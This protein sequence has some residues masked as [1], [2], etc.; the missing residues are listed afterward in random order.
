MYIS[1][2]KRAALLLLLLRGRPTPRLHRYVAD[3]LVDAHACRPAG[4][5]RR[6]TIPAADPAAGPRVDVDLVRER[7]G[8]ARRDGRDVVLLRVDA[9]HELHYGRGERLLHGVAD[10]GALCFYLF[11]Y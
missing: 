4:A 8:L 10:F 3:Y 6:S 2:I 11:I 5:G 9:R 7:V 1:H